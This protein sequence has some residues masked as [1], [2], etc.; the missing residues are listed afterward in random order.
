MDR[1]LQKSIIALLVALASTVLGKDSMI[2]WTHSLEKTGTLSKTLLVINL[3][4]K[5]K[6]DFWFESSD[7]SPGSKQLKLVYMKDGD[8]KELPRS[9]VSFQ[10]SVLP[11]K[12]PAG[13]TVRVDLPF[14]LVFSD[15]EKVR[16]SPHAVFFAFKV[17]F[18]ESEDTFPSEEVVETIT[19]SGVVSSSDTL[20]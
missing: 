14:G 16:E 15:F 2:E 11:R 7:I 19:L 6:K 12:L 10:E 8:L 13:E 4:N 20:F 9:Q 3:T 5:A 1:K 18:Y 17:E